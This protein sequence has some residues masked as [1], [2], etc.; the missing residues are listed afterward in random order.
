MNSRY[1][2][3]FIPVTRT[4]PG[5]APHLPALSKS[6]LGAT[7]AFLEG[8]ADFKP[9]PCSGS[10]QICAEALA[11]TSLENGKNPSS[12]EQKRYVFSKQTM[13]LCYLSLT[14]SWIC[15]CEWK[16]DEK[17]Y[18]YFLLGGGVFF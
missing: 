14:I 17:V 3:E 4:D 16:A 10:S 13:K 12:L 6:A 5:I 8:A 11:E 18:K 1:C 9:L 15:T 2:S 7:S